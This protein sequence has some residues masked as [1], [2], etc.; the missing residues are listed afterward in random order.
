MHSLVLLDPV[1]IC[2]TIEV[3]TIG[4][5]IP[6][7]PPYAFNL[8]LGVPR[9]LGQ[10]PRPLCEQLLKVKIDHGGRLHEVG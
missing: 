7:V 2:L 10:L 4:V 3:K 6:L 1:G 5:G 9:G 8:V